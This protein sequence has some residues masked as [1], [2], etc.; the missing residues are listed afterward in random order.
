MVA[1]YYLENKEYDKSIQ[2][3]TL[4]AESHPN[5]ERPLE[6]L[7]DSYKALKKERKASLYYEK[8][9]QLAQNKS[10]Q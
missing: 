7:G 10:N 2:I 6:G 5:S 9:K 8:A 1:N 4:L 3:F